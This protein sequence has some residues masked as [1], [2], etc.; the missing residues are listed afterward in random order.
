MFLKNHYAHYVASVYKYGKVYDLETILSSNYII[1]EVKYSKIMPS[2]KDFSKKINLRDFQ[3]P[4]GLS[5]N[6][7]HLDYN[8]E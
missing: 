2:F 4:G 1:K 5:K 6:K 7:C 3:N 8:C